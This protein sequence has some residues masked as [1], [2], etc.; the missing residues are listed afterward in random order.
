MERRW[1]FLWFIWSKGHFFKPQKKTQ[2][3]PINSKSSFWT[4]TSFINPAVLMQDLQTDRKGNSY[5]D[6]S[7][8]TVQWHCDPVRYQ[9]SWQLLLYKNEV[10]RRGG[11]R[12][13]TSHQPEERVE[14][15][16]LPWNF[17]HSFVLEHQ[18]KTRKF[19][20]PPTQRMLKY[21]GDKKSWFEVYKNTLRYIKI[22]R[23]FLRL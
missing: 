22:I 8:S 6:V 11:D 19:N 15:Q 3:V 14:L 23:V 9:R 4:K 7:A 10:L 16:G 21:E 1:K 12:A 13:N 18:I 20:K 17:W 2:W 5:L